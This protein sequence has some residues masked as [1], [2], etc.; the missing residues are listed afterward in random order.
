VD[1]GDRDD[2]GL[3]ANPQYQPSRHQGGHET[4]VLKATSSINKAALTEAV[5]SRVSC[6]VS[7]VSCL[8]SRVSCLGLP[9]ALYRPIDAVTRTARSARSEAIASELA[10]SISTEASDS[11][12]RRNAA[13]E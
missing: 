6:L 8:V 9:S 7:R 11:E 4:E 10:R 12:R 1:V 2:K 3:I 13:R 5:R